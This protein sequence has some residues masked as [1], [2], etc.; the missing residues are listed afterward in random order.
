VVTKE[1]GLNHFVCGQRAVD[2]LGA[3][4][5]KLTADDMERIDA[6][7]PPCGAVRCYDRANGLDL[8]PHLQRVM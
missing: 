8:R 7:A 4:D 3:V 5:V 1:L 6:L 2:N